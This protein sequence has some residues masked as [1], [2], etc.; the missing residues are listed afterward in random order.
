M[1]DGIFPDLLDF[2]ELPLVLG[3]VFAEMAVL[4][5]PGNNPFS[6]KSGGF[7]RKSGLKTLSNPYGSGQKCQNGLSPLA[8]IGVLTRKITFFDRF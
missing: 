4:T 1:S 8:W 7:Y 3:P 2:L 6:A 5:K